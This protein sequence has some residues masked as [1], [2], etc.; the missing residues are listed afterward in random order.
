LGSEI[1]NEKPLPLPRAMKYGIDICTGMTVA[2]QAGI[3]HRDLKP[4]NILI[5]NEGLLKIVDFGVAAAQK[6]G[7]T[8]LTK[9]GYV[10]GSPKYMAPEQILGK[11]VDERADIYSVGV[12]LYEMVTGVPPYSRGDHMSVMYQHVQGKAKQAAEVNPSLPKPLSE[13]VTKAMSVDKMKRYQSMDELRFALEKA[14]Q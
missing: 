11:K 9:T 1:V 7:D 6:E 3:V 13:L 12:I 8:Q 14:L 2:H 4:A 10:I 5:N